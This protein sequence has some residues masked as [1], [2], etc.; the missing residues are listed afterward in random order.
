[1]RHPKNDTVENG[2]NIIDKLLYLDIIYHSINL[3]IMNKNIV[4]AAWAIAGTIT[5]VSC[6][7]KSD[8]NENNIIQNQNDLRNNNS[9]SKITE[10]ETSKKSNI[11]RIIEQN[12]IIANN[13]E[14]NYL[15]QLAHQQ[16]NQYRKSRNLPPLKLD[17]SI[18]KQARIHSQNMAQGKSPFSHKGFEKRID[19]VSSKI[20]YRS[21]AEN[22]AY[23]QGYSNPVESAVKGWIKSPGHHKNMI[24]NYN[25]TG[26]GVAKNSQGEYYFTQIFILENN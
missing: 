13:D 26:I 4:K 17:N 12:N 21:A 5:F 14:M 10:I 7:F 19:A 25:L 22:V 24:G 9:I 11:T 1:M 15:E 16:I 6:T 2:Q 8:N 18:S 20:S 23:N 3:S